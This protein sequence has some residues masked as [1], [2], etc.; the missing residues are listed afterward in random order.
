MLM[1]LRSRW[2]GLFGILFLLALF[3]LPS[4]IVSADTGEPRVTAIADG[5]QLDWNGALPAMRALSAGASA[6]PLVTIGGVQLPA[7]LVA[8][9]VTGT[10]PLAPRIVRGTSVPW[11]GT[12]LA[13]PK[14]IPQ[15]AAG[16]PRPDLATPPDPALPA[17]PV[18]VLREGW[19][20]GAHIAVVALSPVFAGDRTAQAVTSLTAIIPGAAP[21]SEDA[22]T[23]LTAGGTFLAGAP[24]P[25]NP[26]AGKGWRVRVTQSGIQRMPAAA[27][28]AAGVSLSNP[29]WLHLYH[30][31]VEVAMEQRGS[32]ASLELR[33]YA[34]A[35]GDRWNAADTYWL[36]LETTNGR[37][38][39][40]PRS[41]QPGTAPLSDHVWVSGV[42]RNNK[43]YDSVLPGP[44]GDH[45]YAADLR[46]APAPP[47]Q[48]QPAPVTATAVITPSLP[49]TGGT[50]TVTVAGSSYLD[51]AHTLQVAL[52]GTTNTATWSGTGDWS[53]TLSFATPATTMLL[54]LPPLSGPDGYELD[55]V[56]WQLPATL[57]ANGHGAAF[58]G[59]DGTWSYQISNVAASQTLYDVTDPSAP[60]VL[61]TDANFMFEDG[62]S[63]H[64]YVLTGS[65]TLFTPSISR[66][67][68]ADLTKPGNLMYITPAAFQ[69]ALAPLVARRQAQGYHV[70]VIDV[71]SIYDAWSFGQI[72]PNAIRD[73][74]RYAAANWSTP[75]IAVTLVGDGTSDPL[76]YTKHDNSTF[77]PPY[78]AMVDP[79]L[80]ETACEPCYARLD[81][82]DP[83]LDPLPDLMLGRLPVKSA[84]ELTAL[85]AKLIAY[86]TSPLDLSWRSR[87]LYVTDNFRDAQNV[88]DG[89]GDFAAFADAS[90]AQQPA[91][92]QI[93][94][95]YYDPSPAAI[96]VPWRE[97]DAVRA[98]QRTVA[99]LNEGDGVVS[100]IG[101]GSPFQW[102]TTELDKSPPYLLGQY[103]PDTLTNGA[104][105]P[106]ILEMTCM[107]GAFQTPTFGGTIDERFLL[108]PSGGAIALWA[109]AGLGVAHGHDT[110]QRGFYNAL[111]AAPPLQ[112]PIGQL[113]NA[114]SLELFTKGLCCQD[115]LATYA[116]LGDPAM[117]ARVQTALRMYLPVVRR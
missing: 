17:A 27:L 51:A 93:R 40:P 71:Q 85:A 65:G 81:G 89:A 38:M 52:G 57:N 35:P 53:H 98:Y 34:P 100:Y 84:A 23:L 108:N 33:F 54:S 39:A 31:G 29:E 22:A 106:I 70:R 13:T 115:T 32:G 79:W 113:T 86:E 64:A 61:T 10:A 82:D 47:G 110:L 58:A 6:A 41:A 63:A 8:L 12:A 30:N 75:P 20:R 112:A 68:A 26:V 9:R 88:T 59:R 74:L 5:V 103:D 111:W 4:A 80:G 90:I 91:N 21:L 92:L 96:G 83:T 95:M 7:R 67:S 102:A 109:P 11:S 50:A 69:S 1:K 45:W 49:I 107:T 97:R 94:R 78:L 76:N 104:R 46:I 43:L 48:P 15:T 3:H 36:A 60:R 55:S 117:P 28:T 101:H 18:V 25:S 66:S 62:P 24:A 105:Q 87:I 99:A 14:F 77:I 56:A 72:A 42:W 2:L 116:L 44:D 37:R 19:M 73:F 114:G 16:S